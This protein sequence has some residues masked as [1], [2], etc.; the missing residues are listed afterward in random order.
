M[1][2]TLVRT[3]ASNL[4]PR[5]TYRSDDGRYVV[6]KFVG[7][8]KD[9]A[10][11][12][13]AWLIITPQGDTPLHDWRD[14]QAIKNQLCGADKWAVEIYPSEADHIDANN[15]FHLW[16]WLEDYQPPFGFKQGRVIADPA[17]NMGLVETRTPQ[18]PFASTPAGATDSLVAIDKIVRGIPALLTL[19]E[20][21]EIARQDKAKE[22]RR[23]KR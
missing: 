18:R 16:V 17:L 1:N 5:E 2:L 23:K 21:A 22:K 7:Y 13:M 20:Y 10:H 3:E 6:T 12:K 4:G 14:M 15:N 19:A 11:R 9:H 8:T